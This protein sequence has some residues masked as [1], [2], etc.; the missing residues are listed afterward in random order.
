MSE[1]TSASESIFREA[2]AIMEGHFLLSSGLHSPIYWEKFRILEQ[3]RYTERL[4]GMIAEH[5]RNRDVQLVAG[6]TTGGII[7][8]YEVARQ[9]GLR[10]I[11]AEREGAARVFRRGFEIVRGERVL[12]VD[13]ILTTGGSVREVI[14]EV[15]RRGGQLVGVGVLVDRSDGNLDFGAPLFSCLKTSVP[16]YRPEECPLCRKGM[17]LVK[18]GSSE[19]ESA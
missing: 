11:F 8:S 15:T 1:T 5:F 9:L 17:R 16:T 7:I 12:V 13:D 3:P 10:S 6:P 19:P 18:P 2:G 14:S 4:C